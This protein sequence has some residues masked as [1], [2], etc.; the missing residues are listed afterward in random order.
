MQNSYTNPSRTIFA[1]ITSR[2]SGAVCVFRISGEK[3]SDIFA[4]FSQKN[5]KPNVATFCKIFDNGEILD[6]TIV[7][8]FK[9]PKSFTGE[10]CVEV[11]IHQSGYIFE[12]FSQILIELGFD[13][14]KP[15]EFLYRAFLNQKISLAKAENIDMLIKSQ[16]KSQHKIAIRG[17]S[18]EIS[19]KYSIWRDEVVKLYSLIEANIDFS[20]QEIPSETINYITNSLEKIQNEVKNLL[21]QGKNKK[22]IDG[23]NVA[24][25][26]KVNA[27]KSSLINAICQRKISIVSEKAGTTRDVVCAKI[28]IGGY[29]V[30]ILDTAGI[31]FD[32]DIDE[33]EKEGIE[34]AISAAESSD[35]RIFVCEHG[36]VDKDFVSKFFKE[37]DIFVFSKLDTF[38]GLDDKKYDN[39]LKISVKN[40]ISVLTLI[41]KIKENIEKKMEDFENSFAISD[42]QI[43]I[44][45]SAC[46]ALLR[47]DMG[48]S[49][50]ILAED[51]R[52]L[53]SI[54]GEIFGY[55]SNDEIL[56]NIFSK[57]CIGK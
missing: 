45:S 39:F 47:I 2:F 9:S 15:G 40:E 42:R 32:E 44:L 52:I 21:K 25:L 30:N 26:G 41:D 11:S 51:F 48:S 4:I 19:E 38:K 14:A 3:A 57:F 56:G 37:G 1:P 53:I 34:L 23:F 17:M 43:S 33:I 29:L 12:R 27:G 13:L 5:I 16:T 10:D 54:F 6:E 28:D 36:A 55:V 24:I 7:I 22:I 20:D 46:D 31:R 8:Y 18:D 49:I 50:E 35:V